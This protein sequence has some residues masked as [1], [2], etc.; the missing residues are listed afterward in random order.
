LGS[1]STVVFVEM[2]LHSIVQVKCLYIVLVECS[3]ECF[4]ECFMECNL[5]AD[6]VRAIPTII[7][8]LSYMNLNA[9]L[10]RLEQYKQQEYE[11]IPQ[12]RDLSRRY[13]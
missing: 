8:N 12:S 11:L 10:I 9:W 2:I 6:V 1:A 3:V 7:L 5:R 13:H 4:M